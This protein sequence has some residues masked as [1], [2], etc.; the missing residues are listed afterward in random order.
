MSPRHA[1]PSRAGRVRA[2]LG[3]AAL[4]LVVGLSLGAALATTAG[5]FHL[6]KVL[7]NSMRPVF[8]AG[9]H[10]VV[11]D[12]PVSDLAVGDVV[13]LPNPNDTS[14]YIHRLTSL[15]RS[16]GHTIVTTKGDN[17]PAPD[18][19]TLEITSPTVPVYRFAAPTHALSAPALPIGT[20]Q[21]LLALGL[22]GVAVAVLLPTRHPV[23]VSN[24]AA[25]AGE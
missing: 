1:L 10:L 9:D 6:T 16:G 22:A 12:R 15:T 19:W 23:P 18:A 8:T 21:L 24:G 14:L 25:S 17:N 13:V 2:L 20:P 7:T 4:S 5:G 3:W 11:Q